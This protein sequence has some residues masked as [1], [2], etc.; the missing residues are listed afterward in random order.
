MHFTQ[1]PRTFVADMCTTVSGVLS[2]NGK[3]VIYGKK[4]SREGWIGQITKLTENGA[5][6]KFRNGVEQSYGFPTFTQTFCP[7]HWKNNTGFHAS[8]ISLADNRVQRDQNVAN[9]VSIAA[10]VAEPEPVD[11]TVTDLGD[12]YV[13]RPSGGVPTKLH[14]TVQEACAEAER[15]AKAYPDEK[16][17]ILSVA[18]TVCYRSVTT[19]T[20][21]R[22]VR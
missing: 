10:A 17:L 5:I 9:R 15:L 19:H 18:A 13:W 11:V 20:M 22:I 21:E 2:L 1:Q 8:V 3:T 7:A 12:F 4:T 6:V 14:L 16:F